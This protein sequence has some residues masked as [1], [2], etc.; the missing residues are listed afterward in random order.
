MDWPPVTKRWGAVHGNGNPLLTTIKYRINGKQ[1]DSG[2]PV[3]ERGTGYA[4]G[5]H[6]GGDELIAESYFTPLKNIPGYP[7]A[8]GSLQALETENQELHLVLWKP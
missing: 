5:T 4:L 2:G 8:A 7:S 3:W 6:T 1:G